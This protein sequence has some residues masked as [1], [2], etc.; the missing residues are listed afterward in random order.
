MHPEDANANAAPTSARRASRRRARLAAPF[1]VVGLA[2]LGACADD[3][4]PGTVD[5]ADQ[6]P[7]PAQQP[8]GADD[9]TLSGDD[10]PGVGTGET[11]GSGAGTPDQGAGTGVE[12]GEANDG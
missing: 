1:L 2:F 10:A 4:D 7:L 8:E 6:E 11:G 12:P 9:P 3:D 5:P